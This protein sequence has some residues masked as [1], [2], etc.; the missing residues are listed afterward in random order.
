MLLEF[1]LAENSILGVHYRPPVVAYAGNI[2]LD[3]SA[4]RSR[5]N[6]IIEGFDVRP[7]NPDLPAARYPV[8]ISKN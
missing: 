5:A 8:A 2:L 7:A 1:D 3:N 4:I 6:E